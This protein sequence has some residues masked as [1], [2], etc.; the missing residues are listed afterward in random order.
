MT[1]GLPNP[2]DPGKYIAP[3]TP[4]EQRPIN[5]EQLP[6]EL[7]SRHLRRRVYQ[8]AAI[9]V[10]IV[11]IILFAPGLG[12]VRE[13]LEQANGWLIGLGAVLQ[14]GS[15]FSYVAIFRGVFCPR[16]EVL[17]AYRI[18][19]AEQAA[20]SLL[21]AGGAGGL[22]LGAWALH[23]AGISNEHIARRSVAFFLLTSAA[24]VSAVVIF[25]LLL[26][27]G[28]FSRTS[29]AVFT[30]AWVGLASIAIGL[31][32]LVARFA[33]STLQFGPP[34]RGGSVAAKGSWLIKS[35]AI[36]A[37]TGARDAVQLLRTRS[38]KVVV[39]SV[40]YLAFDIAALG[41]CFAAFGPVPALT[42]LVFAYVIGMLGGLLPI[43]GG[44]GGVDG[45]LIGVF[46]LYGTP[47]VTATVAVLAYR[48]L[49]LWIPAILGSIA[50]VRLEHSFRRSPQPEIMC[51]PLAV[52]PVAEHVESRI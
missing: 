10:V 35:V 49:A 39:G 14:L 20:N 7:S 38:P 16:M 1:P 33:P 5:G 8:L 13:R 9:V 6:Q 15:V 22:A 21:P 11:A 42:L 17:L 18:G 12:S 23:R 34:P 46:V 48:V 36:T 25:G 27:L 45:G 32:F 37:A 29:L 3:P 4:V 31:V 43:P 50:F 30:F 47:L 52:E 19:V 44:L 26:G 51:A 40:G 2:A 41:A 24:N 28:G